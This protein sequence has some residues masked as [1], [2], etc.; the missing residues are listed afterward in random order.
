MRMRAVA[1]IALAALAGC[2]DSPGPTRQAVVTP[3]KA[4]TILSDRQLAFDQ[5]QIASLHEIPQS[6]V[7]HTDS[8]Y[9]N[10]G[11][12]NCSTIGNSTSCYRS[13]MVDI[14]A[15]STSYDQSAGLRDRYMVRCLADKGYTMLWNLPLCRSEEERQAADNQPQPASSN[16][17]MCKSSTILN[18]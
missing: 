12:V 11:T 1:A 3:Y 17:V 6:I 2:Q 14:P 16:Q 13:G 10:P 5:C 9:Y 8:G 18:R 7:T 4:G 15:T